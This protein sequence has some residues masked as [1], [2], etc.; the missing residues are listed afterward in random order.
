MSGCDGIHMPRGVPVTNLESMRSVSCFLLMILVVASSC[1]KHPS[2]PARGDA[3]HGRELIVKNGCYDCHVIPGIDRKPGPGA[4]L[5]LDGV[6]VRR[7]IA[8]GA[9]ENT[10]ENLEAFIQHPRAL[11]PAATMPGIG[12][13]P[14]DARDIAAYLMTLD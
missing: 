11:S 8:A 2:V 7:R 6:A 12:D 13:A 14:D 10:R 5:S 3:S 4:P 9:I 1:A